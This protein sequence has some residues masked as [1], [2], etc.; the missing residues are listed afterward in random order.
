MNFSRR[1]PVV[2]GAGT[3]RECTIMTMTRPAAEL[4][5]ARMLD[6]LAQD[7]A[8]IGAFLTASGTDPASLRSRAQDPVFLLAVIDFLMS[9]E[10]LLLDCCAALDLPPETPALALAA[11]PGGAQV[12]WT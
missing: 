7:P 6:W 2:V 5:A 3:S 8:R 4:V 10:A 1:A 12:H 9:D 11:L